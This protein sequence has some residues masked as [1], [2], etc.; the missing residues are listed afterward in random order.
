[1]HSLMFKSILNKFSKSQEVE[2]INLAGLNADMHSHLIPGIDD[3][4]K[5]VEDSIELIR[6]LHGLGY[7]KLVT[8]PHIMSDYFRNTPENI[9]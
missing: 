8:T 6:I 9:N 1:M 5:T 2:P 4:A 7:S 3:G